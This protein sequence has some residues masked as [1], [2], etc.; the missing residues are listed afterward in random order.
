MG[1]P[2]ANLVELIGLIEHCQLFVEALPFCHS[3]HKGSLR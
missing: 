1:K 2:E 3:S